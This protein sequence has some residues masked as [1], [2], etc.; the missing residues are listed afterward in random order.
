MNKDTIIKA[1][2]AKTQTN[3]SFPAFETGTARAICFIIFHL[4]T[5]I[6]RGKL[7]EGSIEGFYFQKHTQQ[8][9]AAS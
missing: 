7:R 9:L 2:E 8:Y 4:G 5:L 6:N 3:A 1:R